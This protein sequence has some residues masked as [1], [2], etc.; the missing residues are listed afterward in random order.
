MNR[1]IILLLKILLLFTHQLVFAQN[2]NPIYQSDNLEIFQLDS[3]TLV[4]ISFLDTQDFGKVACNGMVVF[5]AGEA[6]IWDTPTGDASSGELIVWLQEQKKVK[7][8]AVV[9]THF[10]NDCLGG[11][12]E[13]HARGISSYGSIQ[14]LELAKQSG[15][16]I[17][18]NGFE[19]ELILEVGGIQVISRFLGEGHTRDNIVAYI[20]SNHVLFGGCLIKEVGASLG[21]LGDANTQAW[22]GTV[23]RVKNAFPKVTTVI[24]GHGKVG[25]TELLDY[26]IRLFADK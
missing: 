16:L 7:I 12:G 10:H 24:P 18:Q 1:L 3:T 26:T 2:P 5:H 15:G 13:F 21:Y 6:L 25:N 11:L 4:H 19:R 17:P 8:K 9:A 14:T 20:P 23:S 22:S